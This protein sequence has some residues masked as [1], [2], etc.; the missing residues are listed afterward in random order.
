MNRTTWPTVY[1]GDIAKIQTGKSN[2][3]D[4]VADGLYVFFDRSQEVQR[5]NRFL[6][7]AEAII[8]PGEGSEFYPRYY[9]GRFDLHQRVY[10]ITDFRGVDGKFLYYVLHYKR[11]YFAQVAI[12][13]TVKSLRKGMFERFGFDCPPMSIQRKIS[14]VLSTYDLAIQNN[15]RR[16]RLLERAARLIYNEWFVRFRFPG[17][18]CISAVNDLL[19]GWRTIRLS[20]VAHITMGQSPRSTYYNKS[21]LGLPFHQGVSDFGERFTTDRVYCTIQNRVAQPGDILFSVRA[22]VGRINL[23]PR[24]IVIGRGIA[25]IRSSSGHQSFLYCALKNQFFKEDMIGTG[26]IFNAITKQDLHDVELVVPPSRILKLF[27]DHV[28]PIDRQIETL[29]RSSELLKQARDALLPR[30]MSG[31]IAV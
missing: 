23:T 27:S 16:I 6:L 15:R 24:P 1:L 9:E 19:T 2:K 14:S 29:H 18:E 21:G 28:G 11:R 5:S 3:E 8:V 31:R 25:A 12:G 17:N 22:P 30:L 10:A 13:S 4:S 26:T 7:D 20:D